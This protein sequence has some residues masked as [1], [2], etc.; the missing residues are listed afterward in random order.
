MRLGLN[1]LLSATAVAAALAVAPS[2]GAQNE[3]AA[4]KEEQPA[5][6]PWWERVKIAGLVF[7]D[8]YGVVEDHDPQVQGQYGFWIRRL[9][10]TFDIAVAENWSARLRF[11]ANSPGD[12]VESNAKLEP[13]V[14]DAY[15]AWK[16]KDVEVLMGISPSPSFDFIEKFWGYRAAEKTPLDLYRMASSRDFGVAVK[17]RFAGGRGFYHAMV[18][19]GAGEGAETNQ[20]KKAMLACGF[21]PSK[22]F[23]F[24]LYADVESR[25]DSTDRRTWQGFLG[26]RSSRSR[27]GLHYAYQDRWTDGGPH[28]PLAVGSIFGVLDLSSR[29]SLFL[30]YDRSFDGNPEGEQ[31]PYLELANDTRFDFLLAGFDWALARKIDLIPNVEYVN[32]RETGGQPVPGN[33]LIVKL[34]LYFQF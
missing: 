17:G 33:D 29:A 21:E 7:G 31:I 20:G 34:T 11:E 26:Y 18:G 1:R 8:A 4:P 30:R 27:F 22:A 24:E 9:Y 13:F 28:Q 5:E 10:L 3:P 2:L 32:Y 14:K 23:V 25:P 6:R 12:F 16:G 19:N 15:L